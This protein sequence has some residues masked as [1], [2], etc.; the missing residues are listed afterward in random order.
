MEVTDYIKDEQFPAKVDQHRSAVFQL[1][2]GVQ[3][4]QETL[5]SMELSIR[6]T[7]DATNLSCH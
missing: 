6:Q 1:C 2:R 4:I 5:L 7:K 3:M